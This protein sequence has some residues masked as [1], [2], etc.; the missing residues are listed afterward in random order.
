[1]TEG[2]SDRQ[3]NINSETGFSIAKVVYFQTD[4]SD[5]EEL[6]DSSG[7][8]TAKESPILIPI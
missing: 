7:A 3:T 1:M 5:V 4:T 2:E 8:E 6:L